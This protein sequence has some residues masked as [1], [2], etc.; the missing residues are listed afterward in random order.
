MTSVDLKGVK[1]F[2]FLTKT[3][4]ISGRIRVRVPTWCELS[5]CGL[6]KGQ[7]VCFLRSDVFS[8]K[9]CLINAVVVNIDLGLNKLLGK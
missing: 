4:K 5:K 8:A 9:L 1:R 7:N 6:E 3:G 2:N